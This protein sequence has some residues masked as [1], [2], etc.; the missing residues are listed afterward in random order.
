MKRTITH[1]GKIA[2]INSLLILKFLT[3]PNPPGDF[4]KKLNSILF[5][6]LWDNKSD[7]IKRT[8]A[9]KPVAEGGLGM[10]NIFAYVDALKLTWIRKAAN[11]DYEKKW[12][13][14]LL[15]TVPNYHNLTLIGDDYPVIQA[16]NN[17]NMFWKD[18]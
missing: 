1:L 16:K 12:K 4:L 6:F 10:I 17:S 14:L 3:L 8:V 5:S 2:I 15:T 9:C 13:N 18:C 11:N 7:K